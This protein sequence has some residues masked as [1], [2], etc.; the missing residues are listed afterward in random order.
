MSL[1]RSRRQPIPVAL[2]RKD[3]KA[4]LERAVAST[5]LN[6]TTGTSLCVSLPRPSARLPLAASDAPTLP[7]RSSVKIG[8]TSQHSAA[9]LGANLRA[10]LP[11]IATRIPAAPSTFANVQS[12]H[13]KSS[14][15]VSLPIYNASLAT[16]FDAVPEGAEATEARHKAEEKKAEEKRKRD[17][18]DAAKEKRRLERAVTKEGKGRAEKREREEDVEEEGEAAA[19]VVDEAPKPKAKKA[20]KEAKAAVGAAAPVSPATSEKKASKPKKASSSKKVKA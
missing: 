8:S 12:L 10:V 9:E 2:Q 4:E 20:K 19:A 17:E 13:L 1:S 3:L 7:S 18:R 15:S 5:Y 16:R 6:V 14:T 11:Y